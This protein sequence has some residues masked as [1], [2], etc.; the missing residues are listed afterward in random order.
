MNL[1]CFFLRKL[2][3]NNHLSNCNLSVVLLNNNDFPSKKQL[4]L[5]STQII[6]Q[7]NFLGDDHCTWVCST[8][9]CV[10][11]PFYHMEKKEDIFKDCDSTKL[12][13][14][15]SWIFL[16]ESDFFF[17]CNCVSGGTFYSNNSITWCY[18]LDECW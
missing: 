9:A 10:N 15:A 18:C 11:F 13:F 14:T 7:L 3:P 5:L 1:L 12:I 8:S 16:S 2:L 6:A 17:F 4:V